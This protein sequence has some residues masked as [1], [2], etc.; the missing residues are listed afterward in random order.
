MKIK[1]DEITEAARMSAYK[2]LAAAVVIQAARDA[3]KGDPEAARWLQGEGL[4]WCEGI[5]YDLHP[6]SLAR[7]LQGDK[8]KK[9]QA[10]IKRPHKPRSKI[11]QT[12]AAIS[13]RL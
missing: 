9:T 12:R 11:K 5:G 8:R 1:T 4:R 7:W 10:R 3:A 2:A 13:T 6:E